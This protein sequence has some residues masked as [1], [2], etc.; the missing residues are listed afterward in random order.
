MNTPLEV[1]ARLRQ[2]RTQRNLTLKRVEILS[3]GVWK[4]VVVGSYER[5]DRSLSV[6]KA[7]ELCDFYG[8]PL[9][10]LFIP[11]AALKSHGSPVEVTSKTAIRIDLRKLRE[12]SNLPDEFIVLLQRFLSQIVQQRDD[13][14]G[15]ILSLRKSD[16]DLIG[17]LTQKTERE[18]FSALTLRKILL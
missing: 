12:I 3:N 18:L 14:N 2:I 10:A 9:S 5:G 6:A 15:E 17:L 11:A 13:W 16:V 4:A 8:V 7:K 1:S